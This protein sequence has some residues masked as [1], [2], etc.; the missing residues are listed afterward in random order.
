[1]SG[2]RTS[3]GALAAPRLRR[4][5]FLSASGLGLGAAA[6]GLPGVLRAGAL[7]ESGDRVRMGFIGVGGRGTTHLRNILETKGVEVTWV[8]DIDPT[9]LDRAATT[10][11]E[12]AGKKPSATEDHRRVLEAKDVDA[13]LVSTPCDVHAPIYL[14]AIRAGKDLYAEKPLCITVAEANAIVEAAAASKSIVQVG[15]QSRYSPGITEGI[16][17]IHRGDL[18]EVAGVRAA[19]MAP[20][21][22]LRGWFSRRARSGDWMVEQAVHHWDIM[23]WALQGIAE[24]A[25]GHGRTDIFTEGEPDRDVH[26]DYAAII[27]WP[28]GV[29]VDWL[30]TWLCPKGK[31]FSRSYIQVVGRKGTIDLLSGEVEYMD[32]GRAAE[33]I[34]ADEG[35]VDMTR[36]AHQAFLECVRTRQR[37]F[38]NVNNGRDAVLVALLVREA[39]YGRK[40]ATLEEV[41]RQG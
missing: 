31:A 12:K 37:P 34:R 26:D 27:Q 14:D 36:L 25:Y 9:A 20:F 38:S 7:E 33:K 4:R 23:N 21:G 3:P 1:M 15:F 8:C 11:A 22:P 2:T 16:A 40:V 32:P 10:V 5:A 29:Q 30:H 41:R 28:K 17:R 19:F 39:V 13:V 24:S 35:N 6:L 18:G